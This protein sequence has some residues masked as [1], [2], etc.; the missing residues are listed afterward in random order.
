MPPGNT[1]DA[2]ASGANTPQDTVERPA[3]DSRTQDEQSTTAIENPAPVQQSGGVSASATDV[4]ANMRRARDADSARSSG[5][6]VSR[7]QDEHFTT[8][9]S[10]SVPGQEDTVGPAPDA[11][12]TNLVVATDRGDNGGSLATTIVTGGYEEDEEDEEDVSWYPQS[13][14]DLLAVSSATAEK[15]ETDTDASAAVMAASGLLWDHNTVITY[16]FLPNE[17]NAT[18]RQKVIDTIKEWEWY[19]NLKFKN[20]KKDGMLRISFQT[21]GGSWSYVGKGNLN[22]AADKATMN[23]GWVDERSTT[24]TGYEKGT[25]LHEFGHA[26]GF[27]HEHQSPNRE[28]GLTLDEDAVYRYYMDTQN[29]SREQVKKQIIDVYNKD[30]IS[31]YS[32]L[33]TTSIMMYY[34]P[35]Q[36]N[37]QRIEVKP[38][39]VLSDLDKAYASLNY[40]RSS[41]HPKAPEWTLGHALDVAGVTGS[42]K[43]DILKETDPSRIRQQFRV[44]N[45]LNRQVDSFSNPQQGLAPDEPANA[46]ASSGQTFLSALLKNIKEFINPGGNQIFAL[47][48]P[49][50]F[51]QQSLYAWDTK[52]AGIYGQFIKPVVVNESEFRLTDEMFDVAEVVSGPN[53]IKLSIVYEQVL[54]NLLPVFQ[55][56]GLRAQQNQIRQW[57][58]RQVK[59][60][61]WVQKLLSAQHQTTGQRDGGKAMALASDP[62]GESPAFGVAYKLDDADKTVNRLELS[63]ALQ[64]EYLKAKSA[65]ETERDDMIETALEK[66][67]G[68]K[69][70][71]KELNKL[72]RRLAHITTVRQSQ[73]A[74]KYADSVV[75]G[76]YHYIREYM[77][78]MDIRSP[79]EA[80][81]DAKDSLREG[82]MSSL[83][84]TMKVYP[85]QLTPIDWFESLST[86]FT[87]EDLTTDPELIWRQIVAKSKSMDTLNM[88]LAALR[89]NAG[90][91]IQDLETKVAEAKTAWNQK[92][93]ELANKYTQN[94]LNMA[95]TCIDAK[96]NVNKQLMDSVLGRNGVA[97]AVIT[98]LTTDLEKT[99]RAQQDLL[100]ASNAYT[101]ALSRSAWAKATETSQQ[102]AQIEAELA[103]LQKEVDELTSRY[104]QLVKPDATEQPK[105]KD[106]SKESMKDVSPLSPAGG[107]TSGGGRWQ[108]FRMQHSMTNESSQQS[109]Y[110]FAKASSHSVNLWLASWGSSS[111]ESGGGSHTATKSSSEDIDLGFRATLVTVDRGGWFQPQFFKQSHTF[112]NIFGARWNMIPEGTT[113]REIASTGAYEK[114][115]DGL[116]PAFPVG[117]VI[118]KDITVKVFWA[119]SA[120]EDDKQNYQKQSSSAGGVLIW[121][122]SSS[123]S[124]S[125]ESKSHS[126]QA[127]SDGFIV[128]IPGPQILGYVMQLTDR[129]ATVPMPKTLP[130]GFLIPDSD[131]DVGIDGTNEGNGPQHGLGPAPLPVTAKPLREEIDEILKGEGVDDAT[132]RRV[133][134]AVTEELKE[135]KED[136]DTR[137]WADPAPVEISKDT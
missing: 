39:V 94:V 18:Q 38:N 101:D 90:G 104:Q 53:G 37:K 86:S 84:G 68:T 5:R 106:T 47:Q 42:D 63:I 49:G 95:K 59:V 74:A 116:L 32:E 15:A 8:I 108:E 19:I 14:A 80:L 48:F 22:I 102:Q 119:K 125:S 35:K 112:Y 123:E 61:P 78:Y 40:H 55:D 105:S 6:D 60:A 29:W 110:S 121:S 103:T 87:M 135:F 76:F 81:Q 92:Q 46:P 36:M 133:F 113:A 66:E 111:S 57:L 64:E 67:L 9:T 72:A 21:N 131:Y 69:E 23:L 136:V 71:S 127:Y 107:G 1:S 114:T 132:R 17:G 120:S 96:G 25:I 79:A 91:D 4:I 33:D 73:L 109:T 10:G 12:T 118:C 97:K 34:M 70:S 56:T 41:P 31:N 30:Q 16:S 77:G 44:W 128:R 65:W 24:A 83:D 50:R 51:L 98:Q 129:D 75:R 122:Y 54:N 126:F 7:V 85:V 20:V 43:D 13:C 28:G 11:V 117:Y 62:T 89:G 88:Q 99:Q 137:L 52:Q 3:P 27:L 134:G 93:A 124:E 26:L 115:G 58:L 45:A 100:Q 2:A 130:S 82:A